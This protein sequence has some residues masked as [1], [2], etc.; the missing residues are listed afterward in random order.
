MAEKFTPGIASRRYVR[1]LAAHAPL[2]LKMCYFDCADSSWRNQ[3]DGEL[4]KEDLDYKP[5]RTTQC[6]DGNDWD[7][8]VFTRI[9][10]GYPSAVMATVRTSTGDVIVPFL[11]KDV[12]YSEAGGDSYVRYQA[13]KN[14]LGIEYDGAPTIAIGMMPDRRSARIVLDY[15]PYP[16]DYVTTDDIHDLSIELT[17]EIDN[18]KFAS[19]VDLWNNACG[20]YGGYNSET[21]YFEL[22]GLADITY[23]QAIEIYNAGRLSMDVSTSHYSSTDI[24]T[25]LPP[26]FQW[27]GVALSYTFW[28][29][30]KLEV[31]NCY[32]CN[33]N[34]FSFAG[35]KN[36][37]TILNEVENKSTNFTSCFSNCFNLKTVLIKILQNGNSFSL[38]DS[39]LLSLESLQYMIVNAMNTSPITITVHPDVYAKLTDSANTEWNKVL[40]DATAKQI[41]FIAG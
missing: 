29:C 14:G 39:P 25:N 36:L 1:Q 15:D 34:V 35:C 13:I 40:T 21:G 17:K 6:G 28:N 9:K 32:R 30:P 22:N 31:A 38:S 10:A 7:N 3:A 16:T 33:L 2:F 5:M 8:S 27:S 4:I 41:T 37:H 23:G 20:D 24:R 19:F 11:A 18:A 26:L 12:N